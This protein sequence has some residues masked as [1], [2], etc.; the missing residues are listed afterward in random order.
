MD[1]TGFVVLGVG[2]TL[3]TNIFINRPWF[4]LPLS[5]ISTIKHKQRLEKFFQL[6]E[7]SRINCEELSGQRD[8]SLVRDSEGK[9]YREFELSRFNCIVSYM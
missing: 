3:P 5:W 9:N 4:R 1:L 8:S 2:Q 6:F 7:L